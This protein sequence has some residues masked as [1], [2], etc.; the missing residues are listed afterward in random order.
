MKKRVL[1]VIAST[2]LILLGVIAIALF[3]KTP[4]ETMR[5][6]SADQILMVQ[7][8]EENNDVCTVSTV[9]PENFEDI[10]NL[11]LDLK[12]SDIKRT[13]KYDEVSERVALYIRL[14]DQSEILIKSTNIENLYQLTFDK[15][16]NAKF[17]GKFGILLPQLRNLLND[18]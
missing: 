16:T 10:S 6:I 14:K 2:L 15:Q 9:A 7:I 13:Q 18:T 4:Y 8:T 17:I 5:H 11:F 1:I 3:Q 12:R